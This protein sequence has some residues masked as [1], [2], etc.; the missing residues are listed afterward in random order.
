M[1]TARLPWT[2]AVTVVVVAA[3]LYWN[4]NAGGVGVAADLDL[5]HPGYVVSHKGPTIWQ[6]HT[7]KTGEWMDN[8]RDVSF[9]MQ[10][11]CN[12][13]VYWH[14]IPQW[15]SQTKDKGQGCHL[16]MQAD[17]NLVIYD[18]QAN[19]IWSS[20]TQNEGSPP[21]KCILQLDGNVV[22]YA[23]GVATWATKTG[24]GGS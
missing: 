24:N 12:L 23:N 19:P 5:R 16:N 22:V 6:D 13:V 15:A 9:N 14:A 7:L 18:N 20:E 3:H 11:D 10:D 8:G 2:L 21:Y 4:L 1:A 17:G